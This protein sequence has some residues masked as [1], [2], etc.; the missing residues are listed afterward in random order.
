MSFATQ[1]ASEFVAIDAAYDDPSIARA[2]SFAQSFVESYCN[3]IET[4]GF[5]VV[6]DDIAFLDPGTRRTALLPAIPVTAVTKVEGLLPGPNGLEWIELPNVRF[7]SETG[8]L[9]DTSH[10]PG[11][12]WSL[13]KASWPSVPGGLKVTYDHGYQTVPRSLVDCACRV[14]QQYLENPALKLARKVGDL[15]DTFF[16]GYSTGANIGSIGVILSAL[17]RSVLDRFALISVA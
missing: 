10:Q 5:D 17:D 4:G 1:L 8:L 13:H 9:Y 3:R 14:A 16:G 15:Q 12:E 7:V 11:V 6:S 2:L